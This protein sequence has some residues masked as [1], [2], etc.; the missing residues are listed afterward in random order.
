M[1]DIKKMIKDVMQNDTVMMDAIKEILSRKPKF[2]DIFKG[3]FKDKL[4]ILCKG[5]ATFAV[6]FLNK[7]EAKYNI[8]E[9]ALIDELARKMAVYIP[10][11][12]IPIIGGY[13]SLYIGTY[14]CHFLITYAMTYVKEESQITA[15][16]D[17]SFE[18]VFA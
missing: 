18:L 3:T 5:F 16:Y 4:Q 7:Y 15:M 13:I 12:P 10:T 8:T 17:K 11:L 9:D 14:V 6:I 2:V 1:I